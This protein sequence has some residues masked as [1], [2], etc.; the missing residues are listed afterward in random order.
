MRLCRSGSRAFVVCERPLTVLEVRAAALRLLTRLVPGREVVLPPPR[1]AELRLLR[2]LA[3][4]GLLELRPVAGALPTVRVVVP[5]RDRPAELAACLRSLD[6][7]RYPRALLEVV[8]V[9]DGSTRPVAVPP[10]VALVSLPRPAGPAGAR[11]AGARHAAAEV[12]AFLD[13]DCEADPGWLEAL[14]PELADP[15][16][17]AAGGRV[18][19]ASERSWLE[20][21]EAVRSPLDLGP[22]RAAARPGRPVAYLVTANLVVRRADF[23]AS[24]GLDPGLRWGED[25]DL[26]WRLHAAGRRLVYEPAGRVRHRHR[27]ALRAFATTRASYA[28][29]EVALLARHPDAGRWLGFSPGMAAAVVGGLGALLGGRRRPLLAGALV[30]AAE[31]AATAGQLRPLGVPPRRAVPALLRGQAG[32]IYWAA[33]QLIRYYGG[34]AVVAALSSGPA[35]RRL[36][37]TLAALA[38]GPAMADW[39]RLRPRQ[40]PLPFLAAALLDDACYQ[41]GLLLACA[42]GRTFAPLRTSLRL[43]AR[44]GIS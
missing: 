30:L 43:I 31:T 10:H 14:V 2:Q 32:G 5:V 41:F 29:S 18:L 6:A 4:A 17:A 40:G 38:A 3:D 15:D 22:T 42:S 36:L 25:V 9:D 11:N 27:G 37:V 13:S 16:V 19:P 12:I 39:H 21:Y 24:G 35:R 20:R 26:C 1:P 33:R 7:L 8:V 34:P 23:E 28:G 44:R